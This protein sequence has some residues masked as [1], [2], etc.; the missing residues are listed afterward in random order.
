[1]PTTVRT[2][3]DVYAELG[4]RRVINAAATL[5]RLGGSL[6]PA[7]VV[8][9]M[10]AA[11]RSFVELPELQRR[12]GARLAKAT[13]NEAAYVCSGAAAGLTLA[14]AACVTGVDP[15]K[16]ARLPSNLEGLKN[17]VVVHR[18]Q[19]NGYDFAV[20]QTGV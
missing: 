1:M 2:Q 20:R 3:T 18:V 12:V 14:T 13:R 19:R 7:P 11:S 15:E 16:I 8:E 5:T 10:I 17:Q 4:M 6:M 9:A